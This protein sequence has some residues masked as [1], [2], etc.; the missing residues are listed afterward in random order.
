MVNQSNHSPNVNKG[1][2]CASSPLNA[3]FRGRCG[4]S[5]ERCSEGG[6]MRREADTSDDLI[7]RSPRSTAKNPGAG[8]DSRF[9]SLRQ[10]TVDRHNNHG[11][12]ACYGYARVFWNEPRK[13]TARPTADPGGSFAGLTLPPCRRS[14]RVHACVPG[15]RR[16]LQGNASIA[17]RTD[18]GIP[19]ALPR[20][21]GCGTCSR[22]MGGRNGTARR[23]TLDVEHRRRRHG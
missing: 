3:S 19:E 18:A 21:R 2:E 13:R 6:S 10:R 9:R 4:T 23:W 15:G 8:H 1:D 22:I 14:K 11:N 5:A 20:S 7:V 16:W 12:I 17:G